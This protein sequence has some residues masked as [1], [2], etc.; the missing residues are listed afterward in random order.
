MGRCEGKSHS[1]AGTDGDQRLNHSHNRR[2]RGTEP[3]AASEAIVVVQAAHEHTLGHTLGPTVH[4]HAHTILTEIPLHVRMPRRMRISGCDSGSTLNDPSAQT[5]QPN[6]TA[7]I[8]ES[9]TT[10]TCDLNS[11]S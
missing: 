7:C 2:S 11:N 4:P 8:S 3:L 6:A 10:K 9:I 1:W 5:R